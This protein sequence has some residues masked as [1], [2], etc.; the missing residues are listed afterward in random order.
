MESSRNLKL[1]IAY[2]GTGYAGFQ[3]QAHG[4]PTV[5]AALESAVYKITGESVRIIGAG[6]TDSGVHARGQVVNFTSQTKLNEEQL[7]RALN[8]VLPEDIAV[9]ALQTVPADFHAR[10]SAVSKTYGYYLYNQAIRPVFNRNWS[11]FYRYPL[12]VERMTEAALRLHGTHDFKTFQAAGSSAKTTV[13]TINWS[14]LATKGS[15]IQIVMNGNGFLYHMV[16]NIVGTLIL[17]GSKRMTVSDFQTVL[18][19][20][21]R[22]LAG[23]TAPACGLYLEEVFY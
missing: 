21:D 14:T 10:F 15:E 9:Q 8:A 6:R 22:S 23:P 17:V 12:D 20:A 4:L 2:D 5:Q 11:Y 1:T 7:H 18:D 13:R 16:R 3:R 19:S